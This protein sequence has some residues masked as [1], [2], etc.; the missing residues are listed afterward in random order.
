VNLDPLHVLSTDSLRS[1]AAAL[2]GGSLSAGI[3]RRPVQQLAGSAT[4]AVYQCL[5]GLDAAGMRPEHIGLAVSAIATARAAAPDPA[6]LFNLVMSG[7]DV[8]GFPTGDTA[9]VMNALVRSAEREVLLVGYAVHNGKQVFEPLAERMK[10]V[11]GLV[12]RLCLDIPRRFGDT[13]LSTEIIAR[14]VH[15]FRTK[16]WPWDLLPELY[17]DARSLAEDP[18]KRTSLHAK[19]VVVDASVALVT[20]ANFTEA[21]Q[22][23]NIEVGVVTRYV[24]LVE[25]LRGYFNSLCDSGQLTRVR[26][27]R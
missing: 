15:A 11:P 10:S 20:S 12:V 5:A 17:Y 7:P 2:S 1:L 3:S 22:E 8:T 25:R 13:S 6:T 26:V 27:E 4:D 9:A 23:R 14:Y 18:A 24:G 21:A 16:H 19:C